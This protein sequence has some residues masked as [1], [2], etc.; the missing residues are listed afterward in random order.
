MGFPGFCTSSFHG[1]TR[2]FAFRP[3]LLHLLH[4]LFLF[5]LSLVHLA[6]LRRWRRRKSLYL[7]LP[8]FSSDRTPNPR[9]PS[10]GD[11]TAGLAEGVKASYGV[12]SKWVRE[13]NTLLSS[14][15]GE[16]KPRFLFSTAPK[17][18]RCGIV[19][20]TSAN[21]FEIASRADA[22]HGFI[23]RTFYC[24]FKRRGERGGK[25]RVLFRLIW[26]Y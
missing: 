8:L 19:F 26:R 3:Y 20:R 17:T 6:S 21:S 7:C 14:G 12:G 13:L 11:W 2:S 23:S 4:R 5:H 9:E 25:D 24:G 15:S 18:R 22:A 16:Y 10:V 1:T